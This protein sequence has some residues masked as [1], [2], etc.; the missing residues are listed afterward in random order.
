MCIRKF[1]NQKG[2]MELIM[3]L[4]VTPSNV[5]K[6]S[7]GRKRQLWVIHIS[8]GDKSALPS[9]NVRPKMR[10]TPREMHGFMF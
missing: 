8:L 3:I 4:K 9:F 6:T 2:N 10:D 5:E 7:C 1:N